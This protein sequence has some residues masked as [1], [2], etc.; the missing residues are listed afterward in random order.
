MMH[1]FQVDDVVL[2]LSAELLA[3]L[4]LR[5]WFDPPEA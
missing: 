2:S 1:L 4:S 3:Y 5:V